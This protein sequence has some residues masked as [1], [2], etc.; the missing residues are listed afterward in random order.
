MYSYEVVIT[1]KNLGD[2]EQFFEK[3]KT[4]REH[5]YFNRILAMLLSSHNVINKSQKFITAFGTLSLYLHYYQSITIFGENALMNNI[6]GYNMKNLQDVNV[7]N[8]KTELKN[9]TSTIITSILIT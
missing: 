4:K 6:V 2:H 5:I 1:V 7:I 8:R 3:R 9:G